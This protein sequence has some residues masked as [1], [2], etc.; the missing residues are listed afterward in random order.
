MSKPDKGLLVWKWDAWVVD[1]CVSFAVSCSRSSKS[2]WQGARSSVLV[3]TAVELGTPLR[4]VWYDGIAQAAGGTLTLP[5]C[6][7]LSCLCC[8]LQ[9]QLQSLCS[10]CRDLSSHYTRFKESKRYPVSQRAFIPVLDI[11]VSAELRPWLF[12]KQPRQAL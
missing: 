5:I 10:T 2:T 9:W 8:K 11:T 7:W 1:N 12:Y 6:Q 3:I 4:S